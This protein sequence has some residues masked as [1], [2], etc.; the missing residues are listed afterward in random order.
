MSNTQPPK[1]ASLRFEV[2]DLEP[3]PATRGVS[4]ASVPP[5][6]AATPRSAAAEREY[7]APNLFEEDP[8]TSSGLSLDLD[9][10]PRT[11]TP[12][13]GP[14][15][16]F[17]D[18]EHFASEPR[19]P[20]SSGLNGE[21]TDNS[22]PIEHALG[23]QRT[24][25]TWPTGRAPDPSKLRPNPAEIAI[26]AGYGD[27]PQAVQLTP[28]YAYR[29]FRRQRAL[30]RQLRALTAECERAEL[31]RETTVAEMARAVRPTVEQNPRF[32]RFLVPLLE[33]A[34]LARTRSQTLASTNARLRAESAPFDAE[35]AQ[36]A[37]QIRVEQGHEEEAV[38]GHDE[39]AAALKRAHARLQR[40]HI[41][42]RAVTQRAE[43]QLGP[44][45]G[46][47][48]EPEALELAALRQR[49][50]T[51]RPELAAAEAELERATSS[52]GEV[53]ARIAA[54]EQ[55]AERAKRQ[56]QALAL[57]YQG[58]LATQS[59]GL[60]ESESHERA[61]L[62][63]LG[64]AVLAA[65]GALDVPALWLDR[66]RYAS[67]H[68]EQLLTRRELLQRAVQDYDAVR[69]AQGVRLACT[70]ILLLVGLIVLKLI[71]RGQ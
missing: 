9:T 24:L 36:I 68:A 56:K 37:E 1:P 10:E 61:A 70:A 13:F 65:E 50:E 12:V 47:I 67:D 32:E 55:R 20:A 4:K 14:S 39:R 71:F 15:V 6:S 64:R 60:D 48:P 22:A 19:A 45:G 3:G 31:E 35:L 52:L 54:L 58:Q 8:L 62:A 30:K 42:M 69:V 41:E 23:P 27:V 66:V 2:P 40:A 5:A 7:G 11:L 59:K 63:D 16:T 51:I 29:V 49:A 26:L 25:A 44:R 46:Q 21:L 53:R 18:P 57:D 33:L 28:A 17:E 43:Q 38:R 34:E